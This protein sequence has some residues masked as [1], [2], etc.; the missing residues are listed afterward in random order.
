MIGEPNLLS[1]LIE[2]ESTMQ[3]AKE[4]ESYM[5]KLVRVEKAVALEAALLL[6]NVY[7]SR[8]R[9]SYRPKRMLSERRIQHTPGCRCSSSTTWNRFTPPIPIYAGA[10]CPLPHRLLSRGGSYLSRGAHCLMC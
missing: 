1:A 2:Q 8:I 9:I 10:A 5:Q 7:T 6:D 4:G 3:L